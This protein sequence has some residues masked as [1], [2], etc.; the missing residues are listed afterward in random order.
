MRLT[1]N[2][3]DNAFKQQINKLKEQLENEEDT[4]RKLKIREQMSM[5]NL[6]SMNN[7]CYEKYKNPW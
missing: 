6:F 5:P 7:G 3:P 1:P 2:L 4:H